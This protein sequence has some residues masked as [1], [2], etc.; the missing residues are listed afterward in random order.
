[1]SIE[2]Q[3]KN[4]RQAE[5]DFDRATAINCY[6]QA[7]ASD[8]SHT[9]AAFRL[10]YNLEM[11]GKDEEAMMLLCRVSQSSKVPVNAMVNL[12]VLYEDVGEYQAAERC[13]KMVLATDPN[14]ARA[15]LYMKDVQAGRRAQVVQGKVGGLPSGALLETPAT[16]FD[17]S[18]RAR[19]CLKK[20]NVRTLGDLLRVSE[21]ELMA[22]KN[23]GDGTLQEIKNLLTLRGLRL[24][25]ELEAQRAAAVDDLFNEL[26]ESVGEEAAGILE[27]PVDELDLSV[28]ARKALSLL[29][30]STIGQLVSRTEGELMGIKNF[31]A[32][33]L[34]EIK[35][36]LQERGLSLRLLEE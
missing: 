25:Q 5:S 23:L 33:S 16:D 17:L 3:I 10:S 15:R 35:A 1:M 13:L 30:I 26:V 18:A 11:Q 9:E 21:A 7:L 28:R 22:Y 31:G 27:Q 36:K 14:H 24:G 20:L 32:T 8:P 4:G 6:R 19:N 12:A 2:T 29:G 34:D